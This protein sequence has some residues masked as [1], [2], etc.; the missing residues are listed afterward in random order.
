MGQPAS[1]YMNSQ[2]MEQQENDPESFGNEVRF[3]RKDGTDL[4]VIISSIPILDQ[5]GLS[6]GAI[7]LVNDITALKAKEVLAEASRSAT[8]KEAALLKAMIGAIHSPFAAVSPD[9]RVVMASATL[10]RLLGMSGLEGRL[11]GEVVPSPDLG[12]TFRTKVTVDGREKELEVVPSPLDS[13]EGTVLT[14][15]EV[16]KIPEVAKSEARSMPS[17]SLAHD[18][19][20][21][22]TVIMG[23]VSLA[24]EY[25]IPEGRMYNK[26][27][28]IESASVT[29][30]D[31]ASRMMATAKGGPAGE[32]AIPGPSTPMVK[33][34][35]KVL[36]MDDDESI[37]E[38]TGDLLRY[39]GYTVD[40]AR[41]GEEALTMCKE[42]Q[43]AKQPFE[44]AILDLEIAAGMGGIEAGQRLRADHPGLRLIISSGYVTDPVSTGFAAAIPKPYA[45]DVLSNVVASVLASRTV[46]QNLLLPHVI[47]SADAPASEVEDIHRPAQADLLEGG[48]KRKS[49]GRVDT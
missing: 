43:D 39:L 6:K 32:A 42:A 2:W 5:A 18:L 29:A 36:L 46:G 7:G 26:L 30:R 8:L 20:N 27:M 23:S 16:V 14:F 40:V 3:T 22:L 24:K 17:E 31:L 45:A 12:A 34:K 28:Q 41:D 13:G 33:G 9:G 47:Q 25:V 38:A 49:P 1:R 48:G 21:S 44:L 35:G 15:V 19:N 37:L 4:W 10:E 11:I